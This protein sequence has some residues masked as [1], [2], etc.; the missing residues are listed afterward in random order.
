M[1]LDR[2]AMAAT[3]PEVVAILLGL[4]LEAVLDKDPQQ[5]ASAGEL[6]AFLH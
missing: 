6:A 3:F 4:S 2:E 5:W 1:N